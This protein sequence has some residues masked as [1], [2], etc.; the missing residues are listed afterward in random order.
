MVSQ[1]PRYSLLYQDHGSQHAT[2]PSS[3]A[4]TNKEWHHVIGEPILADA[5]LDRLLHHS[6]KIELK[7]ES[8]GKNKKRKRRLANQ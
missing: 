4:S 5:I 8:I 2:Q 3:P 1:V 6:Y 7:G